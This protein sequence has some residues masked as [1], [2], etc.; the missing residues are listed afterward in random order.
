MAAPYWGENEKGVK[1]MRDSPEVWLCQAFF[2]LNSA[3][4]ACLLLVVEVAV[5]AED[6][7]VAQVRL[8]LNLSPQLVLHIGLLQ[9][10]LEENLLKWSRRQR[11]CEWPAHCIRPKARHAGFDQAPSMSA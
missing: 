7:W 8:D 1:Q 2:G 10:R 6:V 4:A 11:L 3:P 9:L 5:A